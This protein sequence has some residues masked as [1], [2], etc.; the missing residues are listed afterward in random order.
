MILKYALYTL[1]YVSS[2]KR[3][4]GDNWKDVGYYD[5]NYSAVH[6]FICGRINLESD[7]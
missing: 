4:G 1:H 3:N 6:F 5:L 2:N 7:A